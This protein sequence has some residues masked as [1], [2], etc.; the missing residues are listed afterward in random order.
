MIQMH[1]PS[2]LISTCSKYVVNVSVNISIENPTVPT[3]LNNADSIQSTRSHSPSTTSLDDGDS[4]LFHATINGHTNFNPYPSG[5]PQGDSP[6]A[7]MP[8]LATLQSLS[9]SESTF[10]N[11]FLNFS[12]S[13][14]PVSFSNMDS[15]MVLFT[16]HHWI[17]LA[18]AGDSPPPPYTRVSHTHCTPFLLS[19]LL[20]LW[21]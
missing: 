6:M 5:D 10:S 11:A 8:P 2:T 15:R 19:N 20:S 13:T 17:E 21:F 18:L 9:T 1:I 16:H 7:N 4:T 3:L 12:L 14:S